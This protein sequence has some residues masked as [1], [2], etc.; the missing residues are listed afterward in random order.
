MAVTEGA[1][2][3]LGYAF[4]PGKPAK[5]N[6]QLVWIL[7]EYV[8]ALGMEGYLKTLT[9]LVEV[10]DWSTHSDIETAR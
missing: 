6:L 2:Y 5:R 3:E 4:E 1:G 7:H 8:T 10:G 9:T